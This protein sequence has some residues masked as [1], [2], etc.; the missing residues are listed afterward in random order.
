MRLAGLTTARFDSRLSL[1][2]GGGS[3][4][5]C[6]SPGSADR[7]ASYKRTGD[8]DGGT[9]GGAASGVGRGSVPRSGLPGSADGAASYK[10]TGCLL[11]PKCRNAPVGA[12]GNQAWRFSPTP[13]KGITHRPR[14]CGERVGV[15]GPHAKGNVGRE[16]CRP[17]TRPSGT[18]SPLGRG[19]VRPGFRTGYGGPWPTA[20]RT[21]PRP[22]DSPINRQ[23]TTDQ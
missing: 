14:P 15:R 21:V 11:C 17:L 16:S 9:T 1:P 4:P 18:L 2:V 5:R 20:A 6:G 13:A 3:V 23:Q 12:R 7:A 10:T 22:P 19:R 8:Q